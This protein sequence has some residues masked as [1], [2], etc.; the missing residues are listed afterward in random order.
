VK[1]TMPLMNPH[2]L[3]HLKMFFFSRLF[4]WWQY[5]TNA[6]SLFKFSSVYNYNLTIY[7]I[8]AILKKNVS[9]IRG[10]L[11]DNDQFI[12]IFSTNTVIIESNEVK[13]LALK[14]ALEVKPFLCHKSLAQ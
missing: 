8:E 13:V 10:V 5:I 12:N 1:N 11:R 9:W 7:D 4:P 14:K 2:Q 3:H 6:K